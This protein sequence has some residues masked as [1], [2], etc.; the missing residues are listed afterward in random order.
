MALM[1]TPLALWTVGHSNHD[2]DRF[3]QLL[4]AEQIEFLLDVR[5]FPYSRYAPQFNRDELE[6]NIARRGVRYVFLGEELGGRPTRQEHYDEEGHALYGPMSEEQPFRDAIERLIA[7]GRRHRL[8]LLCSEADPRHCH[9]RLLVGKVL[10]DRGVQLR[11]IL[12]D[13]SVRAEDLVALSDDYA[14]CSL[15][16]EEEP[17]RSTQSVSHRRRL[18]TSSTA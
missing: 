4:S 6:A 13:G 12:A 9:R 18:S 11:H 10:T 14:Q 15:L 5:S 7:G 16:G 3:A 1:S 8:A 17:W 2:F